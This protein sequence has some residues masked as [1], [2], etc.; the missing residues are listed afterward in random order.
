MYDRKTSELTGNDHPFI[1]GHTESPCG[2]VPLVATQL[3]PQDWLGT[4]TVRA[5]FNRDTYR[6]VP[7]LYGVGQP[8]AESPILITAN[9]KLT[10]DA[11]RRELSGV[12]AW[13]LVIDTQ[14]INVWCAAGKGSF[15]TDNVIRAMATNRVDKLV[16]HRTVILPQ[17]AGPGVSAPKASQ[18]T[19]FK[20]IFGPIRAAD[21]PAFLAQG[22]QATSAMRE[23]TFTLKDRL[24]LT[25]TEVIHAWQVVLATAG[26][27]LIAALPYLVSNPSLFSGQFL[28]NWAVYMAAILIG[29]LL[30][31]FALPWI[32][33]RSFIM[34]GY[35]AA[36][37]LAAVALPGLLPAMGIPLALSAVAGTGLWLCG[38]TVSAWQALNFTGSTVYTGHSGVRREIARGVRPM[39]LVFIIGLSLQLFSAW[40][41]GY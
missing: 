24:T 28:L 2:N 15:G 35:L 32:P 26:F 8:M 31:P 13:I 22:M 16:S 40:L 18:K 41:G 36:L 3:T 37:P 39:A 27:S 17:L 6:I 12:N 7:G 38:A 30:V 29:T 19:G 34:K 5:G 1:I 25:L 21:I 23:V 33:F 11:L 14:G 10:F 20:A 4:F 9:Y